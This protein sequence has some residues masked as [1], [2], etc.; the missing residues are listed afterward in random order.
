MASL[1]W[2]GT[3]QVE[4]VQLMEHGIE[5][6]HID[7]QKNHDEKRLM[8]R[9]RLMSAMHDELKC[10]QTMAFVVVGPGTLL[11]SKWGRIW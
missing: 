4:K 1:A 6:Y 5:S 7:K 3:N 8:R 11:D 10:C 2:L 9:W